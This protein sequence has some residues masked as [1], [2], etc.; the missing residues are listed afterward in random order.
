MP[1][2]GKSHL[3]KLIKSKYKCTHISTGDIARS[4][5]ASQAEATET[6]Q[7]DR[8]MREEDLRSV[9]EVEIHAAPNGLII[10]DGFPRFGDQVQYIHDKLLGYFPVIVE[11]HVGDVSTLAKR[12]SERA[13]DNVDTDLTILQQRIESAQKNISDVNK[14]AALKL[15][16]YYTITTSGTKESTLLQVEA[17]FKRIIK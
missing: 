8:F 7:N 12:A 10:L 9:L 6:A 4:L 2:S 14:M 16:D 3:A 11:S 5:M 15:I 17:L 13:R 1:L